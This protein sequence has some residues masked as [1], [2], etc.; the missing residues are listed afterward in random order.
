MIGNIAD[1]FF[2]SGLSEAIKWFSTS[3]HPRFKIGTETYPPE[4]LRS[5]GGI[6]KEAADSLWDKRNGALSVG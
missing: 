6:I 3:M 2:I 4:Q 1:D 5:N